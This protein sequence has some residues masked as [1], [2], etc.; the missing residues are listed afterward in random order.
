MRS[1]YFHFK[2]G[3]HLPH[4]DRTRHAV[5]ALARAQRCGDTAACIR[6]V[7]SFDLFKSRL[8]TYLLGVGMSRFATYS[9]RPRLTFK[10]CL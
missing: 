1:H 3:V 9:D 2:K 4:E 8:K 7:R 6:S 10:P 5:R